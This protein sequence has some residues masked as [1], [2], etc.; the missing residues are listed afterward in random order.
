MSV[1]GYYNG[2]FVDPASPI[3]PIEE[4]G[5]E[6]G[7]GVYE[8]IRIY[9]GQPFLLDWH[10]DRL[11]SSLEAIRI[12]TPHDRKTFAD[13]IHSA[14]SRSGE[15]EA[16]IYLQVTRGAANRN[17]LFP[18]GEMTKPAVSLVVRPVVSQEETK[19][20]KLL[21]Q[22]D[23]RWAN[24]YIKTINLLPNILAKQLAH[25]ADA[26]EALLVRDGCMI[27]SASS[28]LW[29]VRDG[30]LITAPTDR[31]I[32]PGITRR[33]VL[34]LADEL[35]IPVTQMKLPLSELHTVEC[36][37]ITGTISEILPIGSVLSHEDLVVGEKLSADSPH[38]VK[39]QPND[40]QT[41]WTAQHFDLVHSLRR[42]FA[43]HVDA[44]RLANITTNR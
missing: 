44:L 8:V 12:P 41:I 34:Q 11:L 32:L 9:G 22:P 27:E 3:V 40:C 42:S 43:S 16:S 28:N 23:E 38:P 39:I 5:H 29:F 17:H 14:I 6:F 36:M 24:A 26:D 2:Q 19:I 18:D 1:I 7:D 33:F 20:G 25:D 15:P 37:F 4:R 10:L 13:L 31:F 35:D 30:G 21:I